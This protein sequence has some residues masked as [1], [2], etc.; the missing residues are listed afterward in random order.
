MNWA[1]ARIGGRFH[2]GWLVVAVV[3]LVLLAAAGTR[4]T[5][6]VLMVPLEH[7]F[8]WS[9]A[10]ISLAISVNIALYGLMGP[11]AAAAMQRFGV[12]P[13]VL[14]AVGT[15][16]AGVALSSMMSAPWQMVLIWGVMVGGATGVAALSLSATVVTRWFTTHRGLA[17]GILTASSATG[18]L[19]FLPFLAA[20]A[21]KHGWQSVV[22]VVAAAAVVVL[23]L[24]AFL[25][26]ERPTDVQ[27]R[28]FGEAHD[29]PVAPPA[30]HQNPL[31]IAFDA[32]TS[33]SRTRDF[34]LLFFSFFICG[35]ST[36]G[37]V[38]THLIAMCGDYGMTEVQG[39]S[40]LATM[41]IFDLFGT[42]LSGWLSDRFNSRVLLFWYYGL[43]GLSLIYLPHAFG[44]DF[45]GLPIF[46][47]FYGLDWIATVPPTVRL[48]TDVFGKERAPIVFG[49]V[50]AGHQLG[51]AFAA[52]GAGLLRSSLGTYTV[53]SMISGGLC[54]V[55]AVLVLRINRGPRAVTTLAV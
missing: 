30:P 31:R 55:A 15:M 21:Q 49:W 10:T 27:Q 20:I 39:A 8:G 40:L 26:P 9:R 46:A 17:M 52:F 11:F 43:R 22:L 28:P 1:A 29:A 35:A 33:A 41:G 34:W 50:V 3:F 24:V 53:A 38:G 48:A 54:L 47:V 19:V 42:T 25:L 5:P 44:I 32:L 12:R 7:Q 23:P 45:F 36:N 16:A 51:A 14:V 18:Q 13:T 37:Y 4:A 2:Y 6:S